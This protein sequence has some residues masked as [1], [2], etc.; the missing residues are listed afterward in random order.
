[1]DDGRVMLLRPSAVEKALAPAEA[2]RVSSIKPATTTSQLP[3][4]WLLDTYEHARRCLTALAPGFWTEG[5]VIGL[6]MQ[7]D[8]FAGQPASSYQPADIPGCVSALVRAVVLPDHVLDPWP[9]NSQA[10][11]AA[12]RSD[13]VRQSPVTSTPAAA[14]YP[15]PYE[16]LRKAGKPWGVVTSPSAYVVDILLFLVSLF[17]PV[18]LA[19]LVPRTFLTHAPKARADALRRYEAA[20]KLVTVGC[21]AAAVHESVGS[22]WIVVFWEWG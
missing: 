11:R 20:G 21:P 12:L 8:M 16:A 4:K 22:V 6:L 19:V 17:L 18:V 7:A 1:M 2:A 9:V 5:H 13:A 10:L 15:E 3:P 14:L